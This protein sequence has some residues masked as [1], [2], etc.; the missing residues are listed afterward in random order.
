MTLLERIKMLSNEKGMSLSALEKACGFG[1][2]T[3]RRW[4]TNPPAVD[5]VMVVANMLHCSLGFLVTGKE[6]A[7]SDQT[8]TEG[9]REVLKLIK[10][11]SEKDKYKIAGALEVL[12]RQMPSS[13]IAPLFVRDMRT[14]EA[15]SNA[16]TKKK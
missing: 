6:A 15:F 9:D 2:G 5:R 13:G 14:Q 8:L 10:D 3:I 12:I 7:G 1:N 11:L 16:S 4:D